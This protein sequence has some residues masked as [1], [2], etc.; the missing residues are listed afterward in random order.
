MISK[1]SNPG[2]VFSAWLAPENSVLWCCAFRDHMTS[3]GVTGINYHNTNYLF[4]QTPNK[5]ILL[6]EICVPRIILKVL[7]E[8]YLITK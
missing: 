3:V 5:Q 8:N 2:F 1:I 6:L 7:K 4:V